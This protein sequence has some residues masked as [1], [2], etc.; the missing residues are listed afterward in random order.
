M[1]Y[2]GSLGDVEYP[3]GYGLSYTDV[4]SSRTCRSI[5]THLDANDTFT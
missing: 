4:L 1:Y 3:F 2:N 5:K